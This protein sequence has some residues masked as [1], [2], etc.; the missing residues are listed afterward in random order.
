[1]ILNLIVIGLAVALDPLP[2]TAFLVVLPSRRG[3]R[4]GAAY[5][6]GLGGLLPVAV[7]VIATTMA[8]DTSHPNVHAAPFLVPRREGST[9]MNAVSGSG[10]SVTA[11]PIRIRLRITAVPAV[12]AW[13]EAPW[14]WLQA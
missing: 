9:T 10:S 8:R 5:V 14:P 13:R 11:R 2:L 1:M 4:K 6:F 3:V 12:S 7:T